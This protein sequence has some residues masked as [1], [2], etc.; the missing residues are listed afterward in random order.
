LLADALRAGGRAQEALAVLEEARVTSATSDEH[1]HDSD[2]LRIQGECLLLLD[3]PRPQDAEQAFREAIE[4]AKQ[5]DAKSLQLRA[6][7]S[8]G[9]FLRDNGRAEEARSLLSEVYGWFTEGFDTADLK[10]ASAL[11]RELEFC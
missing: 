1:V 5:Q 3:V 8:L 9:R 6:A 4:I 11:L 2:L 7:T 10:E